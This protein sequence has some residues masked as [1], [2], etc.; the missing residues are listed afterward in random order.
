MLFLLYWIVK[1]VSKCNLKTTKTVLNIYRFIS[2]QAILEPVHT[3]KPAQ[4]VHHIRVM[5]N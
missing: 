3:L 5:E 1:Y 2:T 4:G